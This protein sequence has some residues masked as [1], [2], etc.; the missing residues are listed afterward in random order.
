MSTQFVLVKKLEHKIIYRVDDFTMLSADFIQSLQWPDKVNVINLL[1]KG[2][3]KNEGKILAGL[4]HSP[5]V[6]V[7][8]SMMK[9]RQKIIA[10]PAADAVIQ[11]EV[12]GANELAKMYLACRERVFAHVP[13]K[14][15]PA[16]DMCAVL[17][18][19]ENQINSAKIGY[20]EVKAKPAGAI[21]VTR[22]NN[23][24]DVSVEWVPWVWI[25][26]RL[27]AEDRRLLHSRIR[28]WLT[29]NIN[30]EVQCAVNSFN[31][32]SQK[33]FR[34]MGFVPECIRIVKS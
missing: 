30:Q 1:F 4:P 28:V 33:F 5:D 12:P 27:L 21:V 15:L 24:A 14:A 18:K 3:I 23:N 19:M 6:G 2:P 34:K 11:A 20:W 22:L 31:V 26:D 9:S 25:D 7:I 13:G 29:E 17:T 32:R 8:Y 10:E 16:V